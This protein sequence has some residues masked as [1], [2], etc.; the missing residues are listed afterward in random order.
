MGAI[1][2]RKVYLGFFIAGLTLLNSV[3]PTSAGAAPQACPTLS[4]RITQVEVTPKQAAREHT[5]R[6]SWGASAPACYSIQKF[7]VTGALT[8]AN[9]Q[10]K[11]FAQTVAG[12]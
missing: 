2:M 9:G 10:S 5:V 4:V 11:T 7:V 8:F 1:N 6:I 12:N 3:A